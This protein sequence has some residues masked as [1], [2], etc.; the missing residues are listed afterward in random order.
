LSMLL[1]GRTPI[2]PTEDPEKVLR[3]IFSLFPDCDHSIT[4]GTIRFSTSDLDQFIE[5]L[6]EQ[7]I[8]DTAAMVLE[9]GLSGEKTSFHLN[10]Q[11]AFMGKVNFTD[12]GS[13]LGDLDITLSEGAREFIEE[14]TPIVE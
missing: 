8:R 4:E 3:C 5:M 2:H 1:D 11:A 7:Q 6:R 14:I 12:G 9:K 13:N 10:K